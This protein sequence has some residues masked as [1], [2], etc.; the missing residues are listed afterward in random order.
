M[1]RQAPFSDTGRERLCILSYQDE[2]GFP[3]RIYHSLGR[4]K[5]RGV[6]FHRI[7]PRNKRNENGI[8]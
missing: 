5:K 6:V 2:M 3:F 8:V 7:D 4:I 1:I